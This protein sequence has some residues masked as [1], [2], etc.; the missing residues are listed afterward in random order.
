MNEEK[1][2]PHAGLTSIVLLS[3]NTLPYTRLC[4]ESIR[5]Y[6]EDG[7]YEL[8]AVENGSTDGSAEWLRGQRDI[9]LF[10]NAENRGF[11][12]GCNQGMRAAVGDS[13]LLLN[14]DTIVTPRWLSNMRRALFSAPDVGAVGCVTNHCSNGQKIPVHYESIEEMELFAE[15]FNQSDPERWI[16]WFMLVG[17]AF[18]LRREAYVEV[19]GFDEAFHPGNCEDDDLSIRLRHAGYDLLLAQDT[20]IHHFGSASF[21]CNAGPEEFR[22]RQEDYAA[23]LKRNT[24]HLK[25]KWGLDEGYKVRWEMSGILPD[26]L[27]RGTRITLVNCRYGNELYVLN[28]RYPGIELRGIAVG[29]PSP[30]PI[31]PR[32]HAIFTDSWANAADVVEAQQDYIFLFDFPEEEE[33]KE[34]FD[35][36]CAKLRVGGKLLIYRNEAGVYAMD[37][38]R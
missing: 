10:C 5:Q 20:F 33:Q 7:T 22:R 34:R 6:T 24:R 4:I 29:N 8:I 23:L 19:G 3:C 27:P 32:L 1:N 28:A 25:E 35:A 38:T 26:E 18:L 9:R 21:G 11:P 2:V 37:R 30:V 36:F 13:I 14:N 15:G 12:G 31:S 17:F 16:P